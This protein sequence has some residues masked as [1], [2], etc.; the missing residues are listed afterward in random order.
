MVAARHRCLPR[1]ASTPS[2]DIPPVTPR[3]AMPNRAYSTDAEVDRP[4]DAFSENGVAHAR[5]SEREPCPGAFERAGY[6]PRACLGFSPCR[7]LASK[8]IERGRWPRFRANA[9]AP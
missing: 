1:V 7:A 4:Q 5:A 6:H 2:L 8:G 9:H 3:L